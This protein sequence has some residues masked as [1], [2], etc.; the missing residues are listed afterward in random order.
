[1][2]VIRI[3]KTLEAILSVLIFTTIFSINA[4]DTAI[5]ATQEDEIIRHHI[6]WEFRVFAEPDFHAR[7]VS[8]FSP[9]YVSVTY[10]G[11]YGWAR[12]CTA[13]G[14]L[15]VYLRADFHVLDRVMGIFAYQYANTHISAINP[16]VV[17]VLNRAGDWLEIATWLGP[18]WVY[19]NFMPPVYDLI[20]FLSQFEGSM[21]VYFENLDE[22]F[23][24]RHNADR[25]FFSA[26]VTKAPFAM[27]IYQKAERG[28]IDI[29]SYITFLS[30]D[31]NIG[32]GVIW[33]NYPI[34]TTFTQ[35]ELL[36]KNLS[37][38]DNVATLMLRRHHG[39]AGYRQ[40]L[41]DVGA[42]A[43]RVRENVFN[44]FITANEAGLIMRAIYQYTESYGRYS[45]EFRQHLLNNQYPFIVSDYP[46]A[47]KT[48]WTRGSAWHDM[49]I[50]YAPSPYILV[51]LT[52]RDGWTDA[53]YYDF[54]RISMFF[55]EFNNRWFTNHN[56]R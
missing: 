23:V 33:R 21:S 29:D 18:R 22:G 1:V 5:A 37:Y 38:S 6:A 15:W 44:S 9:Q 34:G 11:N 42:N 32:S 7:E 10:M 3:R 40:F 14:E 53:D 41:Q 30:Q 26:S 12:I 36:R 45:Y 39:L 52:T 24:F 47:S 4:I 16:Q 51:I 56:Q 19:L 31:F 35:R 13:H 20:Y 43:N 46:V 2:G 25:V 17:M 49:A 28:E 54:E 8:R 48:G 50:V 27:Y 55:Q